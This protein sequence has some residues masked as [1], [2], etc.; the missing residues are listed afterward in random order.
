[1]PAMSA[2]EPYGQASDEGSAPRKTR[3]GS[4]GWRSGGDHDAGEQVL[5][6]ID[7]D[8]TGPMPVLDY[9]R[10]SPRPTP[11]WLFNDGPP[12]C[13]STASAQEPSCAPSQAWPT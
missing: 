9:P 6:D 1:M 5:I 7:L 10:E 13:A 12:A 11:L 4:H 3:C 8:W 2:S